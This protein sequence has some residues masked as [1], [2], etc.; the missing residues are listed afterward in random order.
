MPVTWRHATFE[1]ILC[2]YH[3]IPEFAGEMTV[4]ALRLRMGESPACSLVAEVN[5]QMAGFKLGY[6]LDK[7]TFY[8]WLGG[9]LPAYRRDGV[10]QT[11]LTAQEAW[12][13]ARGYQRVRVKT[14]NQFRGMLIMLLRNDYAIV[15]FEA[16]ASAQENRL[17]LE[18]SLA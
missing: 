4:E 3:Q 1:E 11:L 5:G 2:L 13:R 17:L 8:S 9:V 10:A 12:A 6:Q 18:K 14:R 15:G 16:Q 7:L